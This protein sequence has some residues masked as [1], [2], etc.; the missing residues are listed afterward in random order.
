MKFLPRLYEV[1]VETM[2]NRDYKL[3]KLGIRPT[4][5]AHCDWIMNH[6]WITPDIF[7][8]ATLGLYKIKLGHILEFNE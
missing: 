4:T 8:K 7:I 3:D 2:M 1:L 6:Y 5:R